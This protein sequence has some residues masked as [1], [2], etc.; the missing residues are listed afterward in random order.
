MIEIFIVFIYEFNYICMKVNSLIDNSLRVDLIV[1]P[2][3]GLEPPLPKEKDFESL[4]S[5]I[6]SYRHRK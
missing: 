2:I 4:M 5:T 6:P 3:G 1:V